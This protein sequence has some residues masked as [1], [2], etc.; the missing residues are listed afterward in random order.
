M[1]SVDNYVNIKTIETLKAILNKVMIV[2]DEPKPQPGRTR[3]S[4]FDAFRTIELAPPEFLISLYE[5]HDGIYH[6]NA[7]LH[8]DPLDEA[9]ANYVS[10][11]DFETQFGNSQWKAS[12]FPFMDINGEIVLCMD[13]ASGALASFDPVDN[14]LSIVA[15]HFE[16]YVGA[17][18]E[19]FLSG[20]YAF[21]RIS[22]SIESDPEEM[23]SK[24]A[25]QYGV[26]SSWYRE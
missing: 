6:L 26:R 9:I 8:F 21:N 22:G 20:A 24:I 15:P 10:F 1:S 25:A 17:I 3:A 19:L 14:W 18:E 13:L 2:N 23:W 11:K 4:I 7:F 5:W 16:R 12:W